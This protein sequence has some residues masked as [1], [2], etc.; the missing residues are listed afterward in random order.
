M[1]LA[2]NK[3]FPMLPAPPQKTQILAITAGPSSNTST[4]NKMVNDS[5]DRKVKGKLMLTAPKTLHNSG[6]PSQSTSSWPA[7]HASYVMKKEADNL[8]NT[9]R[10]QT[11]QE[12]GSVPGTS[13][14]R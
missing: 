10:L 6:K 1:G 12:S 4:T 2:S 11:A 8:K 13:G 7:N 14:T 9:G 5:S 3:A